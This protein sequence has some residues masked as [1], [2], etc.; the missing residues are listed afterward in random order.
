MLELYGNIW[1][2]GGKYDAVVITTNGYVKKNGEAVMGRGIAAAAK[3]RFPELPLKLGEHLIKNGNTVWGLTYPHM[4][5]WII[6]MPVKPEFGPHGMPG[7]RAKADLKL[8]EASAKQLAG[9]EP[10]YGIIRNINESYSNDIL[11]TGTSQIRPVNTVLMPRP[12]CGNGGLTWEQVKP[13]IEPILDDRFTVMEFPPDGS[14][15][16]SPRVNHG[17]RVIETNPK[18]GAESAAREAL[19]KVRRD[20]SR[21]T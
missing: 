20:K 16:V 18:N 6:T 5:F 19:E 15:T 17:F 1:E 11:T 8:I 2:Q 3:E 7:W 9:V 10:Y 13:I 4:P 21:K 14:F 12:G